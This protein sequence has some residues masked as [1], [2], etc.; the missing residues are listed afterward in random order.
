MY[1]IGTHW[2]VGL[3]NRKNKKKKNQLLWLSSS[4]TACTERVSELM[5]SCQGG[6]VWR[7]AEGNVSDATGTEPDGACTVSRWHYTVLIY[8]TLPPPTKIQQTMRVAD[9]PHPHQAHTERTSPA[10]LVTHRQ[11]IIGRFFPPPPPPLPSPKYPYPCPSIW[12]EEKQE[13]KYANLY[14]YDVLGFFFF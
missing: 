10:L 8:E 2:N 4:V 12:A 11:P 1:Y 6:P 3:N 13:L 5:Q 7:A 9:T 14:V